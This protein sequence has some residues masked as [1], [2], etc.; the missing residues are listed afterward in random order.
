MDSI[1]KQTRSCIDVRALRHSRWSRDGARGQL[2]RATV[3]VV[4]GWGDRPSYNVAPSQRVPVLRVIRHVGG[5]RRID[6]MRW[7]P[8]VAC[9]AGCGGARW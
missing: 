3:G 8:S 9:S 5:E 7:G 2:D 1:R 4:D 6:P